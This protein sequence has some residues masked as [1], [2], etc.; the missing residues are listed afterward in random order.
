MS[1]PELKNYWKVCSICKKQ[2]AHQAVYY[3][4]TVSTC[5]SKTIGLTFCS[6]LCW[7]GHLAFARHR[8]AEAEECEAPAA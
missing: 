2:I 5:R 6:L 8:H 3:L 4:C 1:E 7:D